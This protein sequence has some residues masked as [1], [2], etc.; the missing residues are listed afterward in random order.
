LSSA[1]CGW[2]E[3]ALDLDLQFAG[4]GEGQV[5]TLLAVADVERWRLRGAEC[6]ADEL[7]VASAA[8]QQVVP[9]IAD[10]EVVPVPTL[11]QVVGRAA[12]QLVGTLTGHNPQDKTKSSYG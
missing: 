10:K 2:D 7:V 1:A 4:A 12:E 9:E 6:I 3:V 11:D 8:E 5:G